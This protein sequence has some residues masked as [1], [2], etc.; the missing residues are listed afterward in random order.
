M[1]LGYA[2]I[3]IAPS[4]QVKDNANNDDDDGDGYTRGDQPPVRLAYLPGETLLTRQV[5][6]VR[7]GAPSYLALTVCGVWRTAFAAIYLSWNE[8]EILQFRVF[9]E[10]FSRPIQRRQD[11]W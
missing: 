8:H 2:V 3:N 6:F 11:E 1:R 10:L 9:R 7:H 4:P 5:V